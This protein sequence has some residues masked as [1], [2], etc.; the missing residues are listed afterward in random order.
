MTKH[1]CV[2]SQPLYVLP[3]VF[4]PERGEE[5]DEKSKRFK[6]AHEHGQGNDYFCHGRHGRPVTGG[7]ELAQRRPRVAH[8]SNGKA[9]GGRDIRAACGDKGGP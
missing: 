7:A 4:S 5:E 8:G 3:S 1:F 6:P 9:E 2:L